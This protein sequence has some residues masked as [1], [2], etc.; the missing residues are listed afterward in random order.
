MIIIMAVLKEDLTWEPRF[1]DAN[2]DVLAD[3]VGVANNEIVEEFT[4]PITGEIS[5]SVFAAKYIGKSRWTDV[6]GARKAFYEELKIEPPKSKAD[7]PTPRPT[8]PVNV[9]PKSIG[10]L[11]SEYMEKKGVSLSVLAKWL[12]MSEGEANSLLEDSSSLSGH[13]ANQLAILFNTSKLFWLK[14]EHDYFKWLSEDN[15]VKS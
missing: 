9:V 12:S 13:V 4:D 14:A 11:I 8:R 5:R 2:T 10:T 3:A 15:R 6:A 7:E 1:Y